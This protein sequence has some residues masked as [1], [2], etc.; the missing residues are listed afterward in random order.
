MSKIVLILFV[1]LFSGCPAPF[2]TVVG[3]NGMCL[4]QYVD[5][6]GFEYNV[7]YVAPEGCVMLE[8][9][10]EMHFDDNGGDL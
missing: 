1:L 7:Y 10:P 9:A 5:I 4:G 3:D 8:E 6:D 2:V